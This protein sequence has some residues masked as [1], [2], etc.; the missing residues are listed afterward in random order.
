MVLVN[1]CGDIY[2]PNYSKGECSRE[3]YVGQAFWLQHMGYSDKEIA[4][5]LGKSSSAIRTR[6]TCAR[7]ALARN[8]ISA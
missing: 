4:L 1:T 8:P 2:E 3:E 7:K 5:Q 6:K